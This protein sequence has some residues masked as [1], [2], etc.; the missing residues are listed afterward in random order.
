MS[1]LWLFTKRI[2]FMNWNGDRLLVYN[3]HIQYLK[4]RS[5]CI[6]P[7]FYQYYPTSTLVLAVY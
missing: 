5:L 4:W 2:L 7:F 6:S 3:T 1:D